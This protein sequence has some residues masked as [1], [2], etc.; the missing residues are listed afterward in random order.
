MGDSE[1]QD[2]RRLSFTCW[3]L[4]VGVQHNLPGF[5]VCRRKIPPA[6]ASRKLDV[7]PL[8]VVPGLVRGPQHSVRR[9]DVDG[10]VAHEKPLTL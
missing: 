1:A 3:C 6:L 4:F 5:R 7:E 8:L 9:V 10:P 2:T